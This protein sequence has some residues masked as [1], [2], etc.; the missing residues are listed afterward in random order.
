MSSPDPI[1]VAVLGAT[2]SVGQRFVSLLGN[3]PSF[4][5][6]ALGAS[7]SSA[8]RPYGEAVSWALDVPLDPT[9]AQTTVGDVDPRPGI[10]LVFSALDAAVAG[11]VERAWAE[12]GALVVSNTACHRMDPRVPLLVPEV[13]PDH[14]E[15]L[16]H[17]P[18]E[19]GIIAGPNCSTV[20]L[21]L[22][23]APLHRAF[24]VRRVHAVTLQAL[25]GAGIGPVHGMEEPGNL[26]PHIDGE[27]EKMSRET[28]KILGR[29]EEDHIV[30]AD[31]AVSAQCN[32]VF[33]KD[34]HTECVSLELARSATREEILGAWAEF[35]AEPQALKLWSAPERPVHYLPDECAPQPLLHRDLDKG[36]TCVVGRLQECPVLGWKFV[37]LSHNTLRGAAGGALLA[38]ELACARGWLPVGGPA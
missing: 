13:N 36:M 24:G 17:Q 37:C 9:L 22:A 23:L 3:H 12:S 19:G 33:V 34:G 11:D 18:W 10:P 1:P 30:L 15:L 25:S 20:G 27:E 8:G 7:K 31:L 29:L 28:A 14:L 21:A 6:A 4:R 2:G 32:R 35:S 38:A 26:L 16:K 5:I